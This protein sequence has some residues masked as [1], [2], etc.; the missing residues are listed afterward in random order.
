MATG[1]QFGLRN[2]FWAMNWI[3]LGCCAW[4]LNSARLP[5]SALLPIVDSLLIGIR[6]FLMLGSPIVAVAALFGRTR[7]ALLPAIVFAYL[8]SFVLALAHM[9]A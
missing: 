3:A 6:L 2:L 9:A 8:V 5:P 7:Q 4:A 1:I